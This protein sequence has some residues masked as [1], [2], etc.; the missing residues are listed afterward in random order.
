VVAKGAWRTP[1]LRLQILE[2]FDGLVVAFL[3][4][5][6]LVVHFDY[7]AD[8]LQSVGQLH[9]VRHLGV[10]NVSGIVFLVDE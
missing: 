6:L 7:F 8:L 1:V 2:E 3:F 4:R 9:C 5:Y 10:I